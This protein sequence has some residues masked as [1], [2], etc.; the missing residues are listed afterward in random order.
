M[1]AFSPLRRHQNASTIRSGI[2]RVAPPVRSDQPEFRAGSPPP[3]V[4]HCIR[5]GPR[6][7]PCKRTGL[8]RPYCIPFWLATTTVSVKMLEKLKSFEII[9][10][11]D[12]RK[13]QNEPCGGFVSAWQMI[14]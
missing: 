10:E 12:T 3:L 4:L 1:A 5:S 9:H 6:F 14:S 2:L 13:A 11:F 8:P 7:Y